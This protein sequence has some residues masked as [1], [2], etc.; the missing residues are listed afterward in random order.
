MDILK[1]V[2]LGWKM[3]FEVIKNHM[4]VENILLC[5]AAV[6]LIFVG[7]ERLTYYRKKSRFRIK[8]NQKPRIEKITKELKKH[9]V[10]KMAI[11]Y[12]SK[13]TSM[14]NELSMGKNDEIAVSILILSLGIMTFLFLMIPLT[15]TVWYI[16]VAYI[17]FSMIFLLLV[18]H[19]FFT[20]AK[21]RFTG[22][23]PET[24][25]ILNAR[26]IS[27]GNILKAI[28][29][30][31]DDF[32][33]AVK[34]EMHRIYN[35]LNK[36]NMEEVKATFKAIEKI[37]DNEHLTL[38]LNLIYQAHYKGGNAVI[39]K[40]FEQATEEILI[41]IENQKDLAATSKSYI[42]LALLLPLGM[43]GLERFNYTALGEKSLEFYYSPLGI[44]LKILLYAAAVLYIGFML[45]LERTT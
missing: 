28:Y 25:K 8:K 34:K 19:V 16:L 15:S 36:N 23:L 2:F 33:K 9:S 22:K 17:I 1:K 44:G 39:K 12:I 4:S 41:S 14:F 43:W 6:L 13:K 24:F 40:Q 21:V 31:L 20:F 37:Y 45:L 18:F 5:I 7:M 30:S 42:M 29:M 10:M 11:T 26:Y 35:V 38:L 3:F 27:K 32:D